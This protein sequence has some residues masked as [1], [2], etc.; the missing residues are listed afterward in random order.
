MSLTG[1]IVLYA[2]LWFLVLFVLL[3]IGQQSQAD[4]G[5]VTPGTPAGA[6]HEPKLKKKVLWATLI[7]AL[8][9][10]VIAYVIVAGVITRAD[11]EAWTR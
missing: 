10:G 8:I 9:W 5:Q 11:L 1:G 6:P 4:V 3:P 7:A 2:V